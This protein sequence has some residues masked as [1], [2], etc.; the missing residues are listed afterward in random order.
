[1]VMRVYE[2]YHLLKK[3]L[4]EAGLEEAGF[5]AAQLLFGLAGISRAE[6][7]ENTH[8]LSTEQMSRLNQAAL[9][10]TE[11]YPL[12]YLLGEWEFF[13]LP[14]Y[15]GDGV[16]IPR[17]DTETL[18]EY[19]LDFLNGKTGQKIIDLCSGSGCIAIAV[20]HFSDPSHQIAALEKS[21]QAVYY[22]KKNKERNQSNIQIIEADVLTYDP[23]G[24][25]FD[26]ILSNPPYLNDEDM[27]HL[28][29]EVSFEPTM[30]LYAEENGYAF[31]R[32]ITERWKTALNPNGILIYEAGIGQAERIAEILNQNGFTE[33][34]VKQ[35]LCG[36]DRAVSGKKGL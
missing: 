33:I 3:Q 20:E 5:E 27:I 25:R 36:I 1:M 28:Q 9:R 22:L 31:Y 30:A 16:L 19:A 14:F 10:R 2:F 7:L 26:M 21:D 18:C 35:D 17:Q 8:I 12:Q 23:K 29:T 4:A 15:V 13:G 32:K 34:T 24:E 6:L 11:G